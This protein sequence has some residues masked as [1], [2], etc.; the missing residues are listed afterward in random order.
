MRT[1]LVAFL[2]ESLRIEGINRDPTGQEIN[3]TILFLELPC[4]DVDAVC[5]LLRVYAPHA[6]LRDKPG[7]DVRV[8]NHIPMK[9]SRRVLTTLRA[10]F[11]EINDDCWTPYTAHCQYESLHPFT[12]GN[13]RSG[14]VIW[15]WQMR[16]AGQYEKALA[17]GFLHAFYY[18]ALQ[19]GR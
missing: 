15:L 9:G 12:D 2:R 11:A 4:L 10:I 6:L 5:S 19:G 3:E 13:G 16:R 7:L 8:G 18:Q 14:R 17:L 1:E